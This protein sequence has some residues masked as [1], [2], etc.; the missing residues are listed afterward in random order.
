MNHLDDP[1]DDEPLPDD[2]DLDAELARTDASPLTRMVAEAR[3]E[4]RGFLPKSGDYSLAEQK[5]VL[6]LETEI[7]IQ[8][9]ARRTQVAAGLTISIALA[10]GAMFI[11]GQ[12]SP[13]L[14]E[15]TAP[16]PLAFTALGG[17]HGGNLRTD[18]NDPAGFVVGDAIEVADQPLVFESK[19]TAASTARKSIFAMDPAGEKA[20]ARIKVSKAT[21]TLVLALERGAVEADVTPV[22]DGE[23]FAIDVAGPTGTTRVAVHGTHLRVAKK[24]NLVTV[25][26]TEGVIAIGAPGE[27]RTQGR[28]IKA[29][30]H[31][32]LDAGSDPS[33]ARVTTEARAAWS[34][35]LVSE[36]RSPLLPIP[37]PFVPGSGHASTSTVKHLPVPPVSG[38]PSASAAPIIPLSQGAA[39]TA[40]QVD[41]KRCAAQGAAN[42]G[43]VTIRVESTLTVDV[44]AD[45]T[46]AATRFDPPLSPAIQ[47]CSAKAVLARHI[48]GPGTVTVPIKF[49]Y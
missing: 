38:A 30:A 3:D 9:R 36:G 26:L 40:I 6:R 25:D 13:K 23:A 46:V 21:G 20:G 49:E 47:E 31:V 34:L 45:G 22:R 41:V 32:E 2:I 42:G 35:D 12:P 11:L 16:T 19:D 4:K 17:P 28:E 14:P 43:S 44:R 39:R 5:L 37:P 33:A 29:P 48:E 27:G 24:G 7:A 15:H 1:N 18:S 10:A 8:K